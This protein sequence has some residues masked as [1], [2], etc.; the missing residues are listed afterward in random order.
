M[1][2]TAQREAFQ[3]QGQELAGVALSFHLHI[4]CLCAAVSVLLSQAHMDSSPPICWIAVP[5]GQEPCA[6]LWRQAEQN[7]GEG[8]G[9]PDAAASGS[10]RL[11]FCHRCSPS[12]TTTP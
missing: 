7:R 9:A 2:D 12:M 4:S 8:S 10:H 1:G 6:R 11:C 3:K 5:Q